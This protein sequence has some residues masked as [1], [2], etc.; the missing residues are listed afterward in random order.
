MW[1]CDALGVVIR[2]YWGGMVVG[3]SREARG[4]VGLGGFVVLLGWLGCGVAGGLG[5]LRDFPAGC[6]VFEG[7]CE[8]CDSGAWED[9]C[10][11]GEVGEAVVLCSA[12]V[13]GCEPT[14][15]CGCWEF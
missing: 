7:F 1:S 4:L 2:G 12:E 14:E 9:G 13:E 6:E 10:G 5:S 8:V 3:C 11:V 15:C